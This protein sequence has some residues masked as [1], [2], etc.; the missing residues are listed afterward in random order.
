L[1]DPEK[2]MDTAKL[3]PKDVVVDLTFSRQETVSIFDL[4]TMIISLLTNP[5]LMHPN[6]LAHGYDIFT[7]KSVGCQ[8]DHYG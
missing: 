3:K 4:E 1:K 8:E 6:N 2:N 5:T 7:G